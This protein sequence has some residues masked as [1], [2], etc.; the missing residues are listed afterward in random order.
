MFCFFASLFFVVVVETLILGRVRWTCERLDF[1]LILSLSLECNMPFFAA[2]YASGQ[3]A[4]MTIALTTTSH[5]LH[6]V[7]LLGFGAWDAKI[8]F[9]SIY[10]LAVI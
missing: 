6:K 7:H 3:G 9:V 1:V 2:S 5:K 4:L 8:E 10:V